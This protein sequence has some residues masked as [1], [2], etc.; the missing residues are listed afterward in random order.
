M[1]LLSPTF[2][3]SLPSCP[4]LGVLHSVP[5][6]STTFFPDP[7]AAW[8]G[9]QSRPGKQVSCLGD[10]CNL[11]HVLLW[12]GVSLHLSSPPPPRAPRTFI[13]V[14]GQ[15]AEWL[16]GPGPAAAGAAVLQLDTG[17]MWLGREIR[18]PSRELEGPSAVTLS[19]GTRRLRELGTFQGPRLD[20]CLI[21]RRNGKRVRRSGSKLWLRPRP[22]FPGWDAGMQEAGRRRG[23]D[24]RVRWAF[25]QA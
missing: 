18:H 19:M 5:L 8:G 23:G 17:E 16:C 21:K 6:A 13:A 1:F 2:Q 20:R 10:V 9:G 12:S 15:E 24:C 3:A 11:E 22:P 7:I 4:L 14:V 25:G